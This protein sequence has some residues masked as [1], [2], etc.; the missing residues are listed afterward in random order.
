MRIIDE[1][2]NEI[3]NPDYTK[4]YTTEE[5]I[6]IA[7]HDAIPGV[8]EVGHYE[9]VAEYPNGGKDIEWVV[10]VPG[11]EPQDA[12]DEYET[13]LRWHWYP[14]PEPDPPEPE[15][16]PERAQENYDAG[17][18]FEGENGLYRATSAISRGERLLIGTNCEIISLAAALNAINSKEETI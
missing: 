2:G 18:I 11:V 6:F 1:D 15:P 12:W 10:D 4:G 7:H 8:E 5:E 13:V 14:E 9:I 17:Q 16:E 3:L